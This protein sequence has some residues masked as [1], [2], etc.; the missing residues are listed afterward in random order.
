[1][2]PRLQL[3]EELSSDSAIIIISIDDNEMHR[4]RLLL[5]DVF[6]EENFLGQVTVEVNPKGRGLKDSDFAK[7]HEYLSV[8][9][10]WPTKMATRKTS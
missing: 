6:G 2:W 9:S 8:L 7:T 1:M 4:L 3:L 10:I 5:D